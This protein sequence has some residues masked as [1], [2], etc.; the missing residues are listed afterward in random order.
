MARWAYWARESRQR[1]AVEEAAGPPA[2]GAATIAGRPADSADA[3]VAALAAASYPVRFSTRTVAGRTVVYATAVRDS[4]GAWTEQVPL[5][6]T[7]VTLAPGTRTIQEALTAFGAE[8]EARSGQRIVDITFMKGQATTDAAG[9]DVVARDLLV[10]ILDDASAGAY[11]PNLVWTL[12]W[13]DNPEEL[14]G[15]VLGLSRV[16]SLEDLDGRRPVP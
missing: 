4:T 8:L 7:R 16:W 13:C 9:Q 14:R 5:L 1:I 15:W 11:G 3:A 6:D 12:N 10:E 2:A